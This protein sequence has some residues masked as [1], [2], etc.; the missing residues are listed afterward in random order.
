[1][2]VKTAT[3]ETV[4]WRLQ[5]EQADKWMSGRVEIPPQPTN[6]QVMHIKSQGFTRPCIKNIIIHQ[7][8]VLL[9]SPAICCCLILACLSSYAILVC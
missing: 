9:K 3:S 5:G 1:M 4:I 2:I 8:S 7:N 6:F